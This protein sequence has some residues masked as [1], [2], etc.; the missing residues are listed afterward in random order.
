VRENRACEGC[1][2]MENLAILELENREFG[3]IRK[4]ILV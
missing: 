4:K 3:K 2:W 1:V